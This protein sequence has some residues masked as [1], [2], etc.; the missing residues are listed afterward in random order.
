MAERI[1][2]IEIVNDLL[3]EIKRKLMANSIL[4]DNG[5]VCTGVRY[6]LRGHFSLLGRKEQTLETTVSGV[7][8]EGEEIVSI[9]FEKEKIAG[10]HPGKKNA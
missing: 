2:N 9:P 10:K 6:E 5:T 3:E 1:R 8:G 7:R 4:N